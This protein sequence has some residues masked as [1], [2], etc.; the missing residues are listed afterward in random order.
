MVVQPRSVTA[1]G[2]V[3]AGDCPRL[4]GSRTVP[5]RSP[6]SSA[7]VR[8][9]DR[10]GA[11]T[12]GRA[13]LQRGTG[14]EQMVHGMNISQPPLQR[15]ALEQSSCAT[16]FVVANVDNCRC[17]FT[18][19]TED[20]SAFDEFAQL[21][22]SAGSYLLERFLCSPIS[23]RSSIVTWPI[24]TATAASSNPSRPKLSPCWWC[25]AW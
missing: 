20:S 4:S 3:T 16:R 12:T 13:E 11:L 9:L 8:D 6:L 7:S 24:P 14:S 19:A 21:E 1:G 18:D 17:E 2:R 23:M 10:G 25:T 15:I 5:R 22:L